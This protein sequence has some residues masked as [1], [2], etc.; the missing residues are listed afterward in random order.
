[1][2]SDACRARAEAR[3]RETRSV[4]FAIVTLSPPRAMVEADAGVF[5]LG[6][7]ESA[8]RAAGLRLAGVESDDGHAAR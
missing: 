7:L 2:V 3:L 4:Q 8:L 1:M 5:S 6:E